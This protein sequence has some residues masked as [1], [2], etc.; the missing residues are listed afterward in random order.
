MFH[1]ILQAVRTYRRT[2]L[3]LLLP[4]FGIAA[5]FIPA[6]TQ[7]GEHC[8]YTGSTRG[9]TELPWG[10]R[11]DEHHHPSALETFLIQHHPDQLEHNWVSY[12][13]TQRN[14]YGTPLL[15]SHG[16]PN[17]L[18]GSGPI[19]STYVAGA[20]ETEIMAFYHLLRSGNKAAI[21]ARLQELVTQSNP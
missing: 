21:A 16:R 7:R 11:I 8:D 2:I 19:L 9:W 17:R 5:I 15:F 20:P 12:Q 6:T 10:Q 3:V 14:I 1:W 18:L 13:G 4:T